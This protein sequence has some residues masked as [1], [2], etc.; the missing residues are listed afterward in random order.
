[1][2]GRVVANHAIILLIGLDLPCCMS[3]KWGLF[4]KPCIIFLSV[5]LFL[6][7]NKVHHLHGSSKNVLARHDVRTTYQAIY[8]EVHN[9][10]FLGWGS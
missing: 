10:L 3:T 8:V 9:K 6:P 4:L 7:L 5:L 1:M 2:N